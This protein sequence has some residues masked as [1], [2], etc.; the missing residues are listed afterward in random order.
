MLPP[1]DR[2]SAAN[3]IIPISYNCEVG[4]C[5]C[6]ILIGE[7][8][9]VSAATSQGQVPATRLRLQLGTSRGVGFRSA[10]IIQEQAMVP[11]HC[12]TIRRASATSSNLNKWRENEHRET[13]QN[14][15]NRSCSLE[16]FADEIHGPS[17]PASNV[18]HGSPAALRRTHVRTAQPSEENVSSLPFLKVRHA[19]KRGSKESARPAKADL[20]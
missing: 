20:A 11:L 4:T 2:H 8:P 13:C 1:S 19:R 16:W 12:S 18:A 5:T 6:M 3:L 7:R 17:I 9:T 10:M 15:V 14:K